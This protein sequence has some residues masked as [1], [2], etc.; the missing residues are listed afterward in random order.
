MEEENEKKCPEIETPCP[1]CQKCLP[2]WLAQFAD[3][4]SLLLVF[5][6]LLLSMSVLD[7]KKIIEYLAHMKQS[8]GLMENSN[9]TEITKLQSIERTTE[10]EKTAETMEQTMDQITESIIE[11]NR[12]AKYNREEIN[13][14]M[15]IEDFAK[16]EL[17][18]EGFILKLPSSLLFSSGKYEIED[19]EMVKMF[20][21]SLGEV[22]TTMPQDLQVEVTGYTDSKESKYLNEYVAPHDLWQLGFFRAQTIYK[23]F[24]KNYSE[25]PKKYSFAIISKGNTDNVDYRNEDKNSRVEIYLKSKKYKSKLEKN[26]S[27]LFD[28]IGD[29]DG[30]VFKQ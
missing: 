25:G 1:E 16:L 9:Q 6:V 19:E 30:K 17:G 8:M 27:T 3:L 18:K 23:E 21:L 2:G 5:F 13:E 14:D 26:E 15:E 24:K 4:M 28:K 10:M 29:I 22:L 11:L 12:R 7:D 20:F